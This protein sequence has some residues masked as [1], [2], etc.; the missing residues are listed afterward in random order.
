M[1][2]A[3]KRPERAPGKLRS[4]GKDRKREYGGGTLYQRADGIWEG[5]ISL[6]TSPDG[7]RLR[8]KA[9]FST[10]KIK[11]A[12]KLDDLKDDLKN[13]RAPLPARKIKVAD[14]I[15]EWA[16]QKKRDW[17]P[18]HYKN[19]LSSIKQQIVP[20]IGGVDCKTLNTDHFEYLIT[21]MEDQTKIVKI[22]DEDGKVIDEQEQQRWTSR[23]RRIA[24]DRAHEWLQ[25]EQRKRPRLIRENY[26]ALV[27]RPPSTSDE[28]GIHTAE[29]V[30]TV[31]ASAI[32]HS[33]PLTTLWAARYVTG[34]RRGELLGLTADRLNLEDLTADISW[35]LQQLPLKPGMKN[36]GDPHRFDAMDN[37]EIRP[38]YKNLAW[39]K[40]KTRKSHIIPIPPTLGTM[41]EIDL[42]GRTP[43]RFGLIWVT[44]TGLPIRREYEAEAWEAA[45]VRAGVP[46]IKGHGTRH[47][48]NTLIRVEEALRMQLLGHNNA[49]SNRLYKRKNLD[50]LRVGQNALGDLVLPKN[51]VPADRRRR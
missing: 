32:E 15:S 40:P 46:V 22:K 1:S 39:V 45:Q 49:A 23:T 17:S 38:C 25:D 21:W 13:G 20:S 7:K 6:G 18:N 41:I 14:R 9:V 47:T 31:L 37:Y 30:T 44:K 2:P 26:A 4:A 51:A 27:G 8:S 34:K 28:Y 12:K 3:K 36:S 19:V 24:F 35:Q 10:D 29:Q 42:E 11:C 43:N 16:Q 50:E 48:A 5:R 33:D